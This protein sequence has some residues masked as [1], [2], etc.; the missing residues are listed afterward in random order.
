MT[1]QQLVESLRDRLPDYKPGDLAIAVDI[2]F[3]SI[4]DALIEG[5]RIEIRGFGVFSVK[6]RKPRVGRNPRTGE[7][8]FIPERRT[9]LFKPG[10]KLKEMVDYA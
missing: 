10:K 5:D 6:T 3:D 9:L 1:K 2:L 4:R 7:S 8:V